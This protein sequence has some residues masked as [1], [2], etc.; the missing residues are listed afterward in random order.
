MLS[1]IL[2]TVIRTR[3]STLHSEFA[4]HARRLKKL[5]RTPF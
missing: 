5:P 4:V 1:A 2:L 3:L